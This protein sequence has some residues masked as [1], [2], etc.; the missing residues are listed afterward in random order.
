MGALRGKQ[1][2]TEAYHL[3]TSDQKEIDLLVQTGTELWAI[4]AKLTTQP[5][6]HS[7]ARLDAF[8]DLVGAN[9]RFLICRSS[10]TIEAGARIVC[11]LDGFCNYVRS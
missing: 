6:I 10:E 4:E 2:G 9:K 8:A 3:R 5:G 1:R 11:D 7:L